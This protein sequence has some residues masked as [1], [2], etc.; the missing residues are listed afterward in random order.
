[1][2]CERPLELRSKGVSEWVSGFEGGAGFQAGPNEIR[3]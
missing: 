3:V 2:W 1:M